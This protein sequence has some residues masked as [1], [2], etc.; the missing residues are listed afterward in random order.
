MPGKIR[1]GNKALRVG[2]RE[3]P[4]HC[5]GRFPGSKVNQN[6]SEVGT[7]TLSLVTSKNELESG[8]TRQFL[9]GFL[10][11]LKIL[12]GLGNHVIKMG[13]AYSNI[14]KKVFFGGVGIGIPS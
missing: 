1:P 2:H 9:V 4:W 14:A 5:T 13:R 3:L 11:T 10:E 12:V 6:I 8:E 7:F